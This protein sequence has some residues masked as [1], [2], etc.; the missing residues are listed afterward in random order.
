M[1]I[2]DRLFIL[3]HQLGAKGISGDYRVRAEAFHLL[4]QRLQ[5]MSMDG[6]SPVSYTH[7]GHIS[8]DSVEIFVLDEA[9]RMLDMG[10]INDVKKVIRQLP[11]KRQN[12]LFS[13]TLPAEIL[14]LIDS[15]LHDYVKVM[16]SPEAPTV[17]KIQQSLYFVDKQN[18]APLL[19]D[20]LKEKRVPSALVFT[21]TKHGADKLVRYLLKAGRCG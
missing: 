11:P 13:A 3:A 9:D 1:C 12:L 14:A 6:M 15:M 19:C 10:F 2:R 7:L 18:K 8:L 5:H 16:V 17:E 4:S 21:R 20:L